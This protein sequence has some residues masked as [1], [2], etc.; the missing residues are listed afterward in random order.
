MFLRMHG[1]LE[2]LVKV[3]KI[4]AQFAARLDK[5]SP[6]KYVMHQEWGVG[7]V[8]NWS[9]PKQAVKINFERKPGYIMGLKLAFNQLTP[10]PEGHFLIACYDDPEGCRKQA[11]GKDTILTF[12]ASVLEH[13]LSLR[14]GIDEVLPMQPEDM[15]RFLSGRVIPA[16]QWKLW[17]E[18]ARAAMRQSP[19]FRL[20]TKR[21]EA[22]R[23]RQ[24][25]SAAEALLADY[26]DATS[27][28][29]CVRILDQAH[30]NE[31]LHGELNIAARL[32][33]AMERDIERDHMEPQHVLELIIIRDEIPAKAASTNEEREALNAALT[34]AGVTTRTTLAEKLSSIPAEDLV[35]YI[36]E[37]SP[38]RQLCVYAAIKDAYPDT[39]QDYLTH[40]FLHGASRVTAPVAD[41]ILS[42][43]SKEQLFAEIFS[44]ISRQSLQPSV[45]IWIC[46]E[47]NGVAGEI[48]EKAKMSLGSAIISAI[49]R[50]SADGAPNRALRL[51][52]MLMEDKDLAPDLVRG[53]TEPEARPFAKAIY[54]SSMLADLDRN[55]LL[56]NMMKVHP[57]LQEI[58]LTRNAP[59][60]KQT[61]YV[62][63]R[64]F[65]ARKA[66]YEELVN[67][68]IPKNKHDL[69]ITRAEG[70]LR[71]NGGYQDAKATRQVLMRRSEELSRLLAQAQPTD[72]RGVSCDQTSMGTAV[73]FVTDNGQE[74]VYTILG[75]WDSDPEAHIVAYSS[76]LG[77][78]LLGHKVGDSLRLPIEIG[79]EQVKMTV[80]S[81]APAPESLIYP[82]E[83][84]PE[85]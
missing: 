10:V 1:D 85:A 18:K 56:A 53:L 12:I 66:E 71:E 8:E 49:E 7:K 28:E 58:A 43:G 21:G 50:D 65:A 42:H 72:F 74:V 73:T 84:T 47:R 16:D 62:S 35:Q 69:E 60:A 6:G 77:A 14:E 31:V 70:D 34:E 9:I 38:A 22:I 51:R 68:K 75:A 63:L 82:D 45:L 29:T 57:G 36:G 25:N 32:I 79:G 40:I 48:V 41:F 46:K 59:K 11:E 23:T 55:F 2:K 44:G 17:W 3:G 26:T 67:V 24:A 81:I 52:N 19:K 39:W 5:F 13:N 61:L 27:L 83:P 78:R 4:P 80:K 37:L 30:L 15:E 54:D 64:S 76:K 20:P 33:A